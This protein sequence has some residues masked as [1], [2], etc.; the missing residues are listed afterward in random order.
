MKHN[1]ILVIENV[2]IVD[3]WKVLYRI[4]APIGESSE[5]VTCRV[6]A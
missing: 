1:I 6:I 4:M 2:T 3:I 5:S